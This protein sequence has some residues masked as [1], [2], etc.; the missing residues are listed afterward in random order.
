MRESQ[1]AQE[2]VSNYQGSVLADQTKKQ[3]Q[4][5]ERLEKLNRE[6]AQQQN[7]EKVRRRRV[8]LL[9]ALPDEPPATNSAVTTV[10]LRFI[11]NGQTSQRRFDASTTR[12]VDIFNWI[13][14]V[15]EVEREHIVLQT[16]NGQETYDWITCQSSQNHGDT[17][18][19]A[20]PSTTPTLLDMK[21]GKM[22]ALRVRVVQ[23]DAAGAV[24]SGLTKTASNDQG[25][26]RPIELE[27]KKAQLGS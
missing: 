4:E 19:D 6:R 26:L 3:R 17:S 12:L 25:D 10:A 9:A 23:S 22:R 27:S 2:R 11:S 24:P 15:F 1:Q 7:M 16:M 8:Q 18:D 21:W 5:Q 13:D 14:A 20:A